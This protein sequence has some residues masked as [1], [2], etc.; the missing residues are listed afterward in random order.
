MRFS[1]QVSF[2]LFAVLVATFAEGQNTPRHRH[3]PPADTPATASQQAV[4]PPPT[5]IAASSL[6]EQPAK[7]AQ[8]G[9][10]AG[11]LSVKADNSELSEILHNISAQ[12]GMSVDGISRDQ[13]IFGS[14]G[15]AAPREVLSALLDGLGYN[16][17][18]VGSLDNGAPREL[19][20]TPR[21]SGS[22]APGNA[23]APRVRT[24]NTNTSND[25]EDE[26][27]PEQQD[28]PIPPRPE[29]AYP[30]DGNQSPDQQQPGAPG[31]QAPVRTPQQMLQELQQMRQQQQQF[32][33][34]QANPQ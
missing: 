17:M 30:P 18:M 27:T 6:L 3:Q 5:P 19:M 31:Q 32:Q 12:T 28:A 34:Q 22:S 26:S 10:D 20:L 8:V 7:P 29:A 16:V 25:D 14:Y 33:Q 2:V 1:A 9:M 15:P 24:E 21:T 13:R 11:K 23:Q 4:A